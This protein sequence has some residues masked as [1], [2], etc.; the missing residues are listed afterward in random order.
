MEQT[1]ISAI[2]QYI[3]DAVKAKRIELG[4]SQSELANLIDVSPGFIG[5]AENPKYRTKYNFTLINEI[6]RICK[7]SPK[8]FLPEKPVGK[9]R[10]S[11]SIS[12]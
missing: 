8:D 9:Q 2:D 6:A 5:N 10:I 3:I 11:K 7:C 4:Y 1:N 12:T